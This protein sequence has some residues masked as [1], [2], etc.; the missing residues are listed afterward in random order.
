MLIYGVQP[1]YPNE[2]G[3]TKNDMLKA[4]D[5]ARQVRDF[6]LLAEIRREIN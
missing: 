5:Y 1:R 4:L 2:L 6:E 3:V